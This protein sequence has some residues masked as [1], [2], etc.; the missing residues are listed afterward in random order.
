VACAFNSSSWEAEAGGS[1]WIQKP[2]WSTGWI[3]GH[4]ELLN[5]TLS[6]K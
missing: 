2:A 1:L 5:E 6:Q 4:P 3:P